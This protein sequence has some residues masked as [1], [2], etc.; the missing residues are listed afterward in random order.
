MPYSTAE[1]LEAQDLMKRVLALESDP[2]FQRLK[3]KIEQTNFFRILGTSQTERWH[4]SFWAWI[5]DPSGSHGMGGFAS[6][7]LL[8]MSSDKEGNIQS[9]RL[10]KKRGTGDE[11]NWDPDRQSPS[12]RMEL[13]L[14]DLVSF[15]QSSCLSA[16]SRLTNFS[17]IQI[18][19]SSKSNQLDI[20]LI[21]QGDEYNDEYKNEKITIL[22]GIECKVN[23]KYDPSQLK[24]YS[25]WLHENPDPKK[26]K[27]KKVSESV[28][29]IMLA[30]NRDKEPLFSIGYFLSSEKP[31]GGSGS[32]PPEDLERPWISITYQNMIDEILYPMVEQSRLNERSK[33]LI[34]QYIELA[35]SPQSE[36]YTEATEMQ[37]DLVGKVIEKHLD[38]FKMIAKVLEGDPE[39]Q[40]LGAAISD[41]CSSN[42]T[43]AVQ[44]TPKDLFDMGYAKPGDRVV[45]EPVKKRRT[46]EK[47]FEGKVVAELVD[48]NGHSD[49][50]AAL[51]LVSGGNWGIDEPE[52]ATGLLKRIYQANQTKFSGSGNTYWKFENGDLAGQ[53]LTEVY[54]RCR[55]EMAEGDA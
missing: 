20:L 22:I 40:E 30:C 19:G 43:R 33:M 15:N 52:T 17:E 2:D 34:Q 51:K 53:S 32:P 28:V 42:S 45:H 31:S 7:R 26:I 24:R 49:Q 3:E 39:R 41:T 55:E 23:A 25:K 11:I 16:P 4:S 48:V 6:R 12:S 21:L 35:G 5:L 47:A 1:T 29:D 50:R 38:T 10:G 46:G 13:K 44:L 14:T 9:Q 27:N 8:A 54:D 37:K 36:I 18:D